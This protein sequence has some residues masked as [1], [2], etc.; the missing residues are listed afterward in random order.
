MVFRCKRHS[1]PL[2]TINFYRRSE[3]KWLPKDLFE[4]TVEEKFSCHACGTP[5]TPKVFNTHY[6]NLHVP[7]ISKGSTSATS[8]NDLLADF[9]AR[10]SQRHQSSS[11]KEDS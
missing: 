1:R 4:V 2:I 7:P 6:L 9:F 5:Q 11:T 8:V 3:L 10:K